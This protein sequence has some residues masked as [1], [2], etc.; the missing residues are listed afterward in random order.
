MEV[1]ALRTRSGWALVA[2]VAW[3][4]LPIDSAW[5]A[6][7]CPLAKATPSKI[8]SS[9]AALRDD[10]TCLVKASSVVAGTRLYDV[11]SRAEYQQFHIP[12]ATSSSVSEVAHL[13]RSNTTPAII[14][15]GGKFHSD[16]LLLC[17][18]LRSA[19]AR[20]FKILD[21]GIAQWS[22]SNRHPERLVAS[23]IDDA[24]VAALLTDPK[25]T[26]SS[27]AGNI[28]SLLSEHGIRQGAAIASGKRVLIVDPSTPDEKITALLDVRGPTAFY[29]KGDAPQ[30]LA[31]LHSHL[32]Q[33]Q[34]RVAGPAQSATCSAL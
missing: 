28:R 7:T 1:S 14:Y 29:W 30:L 31:L 20:N 4:S 13:L 33:H 25:T 24:E 18:R 2:A 32:A 9:A 6:A 17:A 19:G 11:R 16:A 23:R 3:F 15:E 10:P 26:A 5:S 12:G 34:K 21:G 27:S 8:E 22:Q